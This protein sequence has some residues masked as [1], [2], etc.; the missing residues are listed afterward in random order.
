MKIIAPTHC[1]SCNSELV[2]SN[3]ILYCV[4]KSCPAQGLKTIENFA[5]ILKIMGLGPAR[6][7]ALDI[8]SIAELYKL[9]EKYIVSKL[10][11]TL[12]SKLYAQIQSSKNASLNQ[13]LP[14]LGIPLIGK[15]AADKICAKFTNL[16]EITEELALTILGPQATSNLM[17]WIQTEEY[18]ELPFSFK[19][20]KTESV[21]GPTVC[22][23]GKLSSFKTKAEAAKY[24][25]Q[26]G[27]RVVNSVTKDTVYLVNESGV[28]SEKTRK[29]SA[30]GTIIINNILE[31]I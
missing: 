17:A 23:T 5:K 16:N 19:S 10:G 28:E 30:N 27:Y 14:A 8:Y 2:L 6:I 22:I 12:G 11:D 15:V 1:P 18:K 13:V 21:N 26:K 20:E 7:E 24:L 25:T 9:S 31:L 3:S 4:N 29:A